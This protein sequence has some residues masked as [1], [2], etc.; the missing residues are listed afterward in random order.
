MSY[1][2]VNSIESLYTAAK[3][4][5]SELAELWEERL[6]LIKHKVKFV[7]N[8][9]TIVVLE[10]LSPLKVMGKWVPELVY[11]AGGEALLNQK[12]ND[13]IEITIE[14]LQAVDADGIIISI[15]DKSLAEVREELEKV[16]GTEAW[17]S[18]K[19]VQKGHVFI[20]EGKSSFHVAG[21]EIIE[22]GELIAEI[23]QVNQFY[24]GMEGE[25][26]EQWAQKL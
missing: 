9:P 20:S 10:S 26:W 14:E 25:R 19:S 18:L 5:D 24:Y 17:Q 16:I 21:E 6:E 11:N 8:R 15:K 12:E 13:S 4:V 22:T 3:L 1:K 2:S 23:L 7:K